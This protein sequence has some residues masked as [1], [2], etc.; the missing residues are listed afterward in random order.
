MLDFVC[1]YNEST[2]FTH[3]HQTQ[4]NRWWWPFGWPYWEIQTSRKA[5]I[6]PA[7]ALQFCRCWWQGWPPSRPAFGGLTAGPTVGKGSRGPAGEDTA[8][9]LATQLTCLLHSNT[10]SAPVPSHC[11]GPAA[12]GLGFPTQAVALW[13]GHAWVSAGLP[14]I[15]QSLLA[16]GSSSPG[17]DAVAPPRHRSSR[18]H[19]AQRT[20]MKLRAVTFIHKTWHGDGGTAGP[21][22]PPAASSRRAGAW[23]GAATGLPSG[24][25]AVPGGPGDA[26]PLEPW[27]CPRACTGCGRGSGDAGPGGSGSAVSVAAGPPL[28][29][30]PFPAPCP[31][32]PTSS[33]GSARC[34]ALQPPSAH[35][36]P[37]AQGSVLGRWGHGGRAEA[38]PW[39]SIPHSPEVGEVPLNKAL[40]LVDHP[41]ERLVQKGPFLTQLGTCSLWWV[42]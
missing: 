13:A 32:R 40:G 35:L 7:T 9:A 4:K 11:Q 27:T 14:D 1:C 31:H 34:G 33:M 24:E 5:E 42:F 36:H 19:R 39:L 23:P 15:L 41:G 16:L 12:A 26:Q 28:P 20:G 37:R 2:R 29:S 10:P 21:R 25:R 3:L 8:C 17:T 22:Q 38:W 30:P 18:T 6:P